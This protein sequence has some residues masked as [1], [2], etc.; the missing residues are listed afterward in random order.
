MSFR[1]LG[2]KIPCT[3][4]WSLSQGER[5]P[6]S[7]GKTV[8]FCDSAV[9]IRQLTVIVDII[10]ADEVIISRRR[11][12]NRERMVFAIAYIHGSA[13]KVTYACLCRTVVKVGLVLAL[14]IGN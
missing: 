8:R 5:A 7:S 3:S 9:D 2:S 4:L 1:I 13:I 12:G 6:A 14:Q 10:V 11:F